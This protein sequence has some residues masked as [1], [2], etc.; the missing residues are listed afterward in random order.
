[1]GG[2]LDSLLKSGVSADGTAASKL[3]SSSS[4]AVLSLGDTT[5]LV[6]RSSKRGA[7]SSDMDSMEKAQKWAAQRNHDVAL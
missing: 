2:L 4:L 3:G 6:L 7:A 5:G 1:M